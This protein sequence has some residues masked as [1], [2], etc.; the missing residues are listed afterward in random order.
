M[1]ARRSLAS[2][3][4]FDVGARGAA[5]VFTV[6]AFFLFPASA[7]AQCGAKRSTCSSC[8]DGVHARAPARSAW[9]VDHAFAD[10]CTACHAGDGDAPEA[11]A[12]HAAMQAPLA[13]GGAPCR[14]CHADATAR[15]ERYASAIGSTPPTGGAGGAPPTT[16]TTTTTT[17]SSAVRSSLRPQDAFGIGLVAA[18]GA[19]VVAWLAR[20]DT[21][22]STAIAKLRS[23]SWSPYLGGVVLGIV[24]TISLAV[25]GHRL[26]GAG[27]YQHLSGYL[28]RPLSPSSIYWRHIVP[29]GLTWDVQIAIGALAGALVSSRLARTFRVR[30]MPDAGW[31]EAFG[32]RVAVRWAIAFFGS[33]LTEIGAGIAGGCTASLA[34]SGG[35]VL[36]PAAF[37]FM[38][39]MFAGG[40]PALAIATYVGRLLSVR[41]RR[42]P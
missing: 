30:T 1:R 41:R 21:R 26:S 31:R 29:T 9:H 2:R 40:I 10:V 16:T 39:G 20:R 32:D 36:A 24:V 28:G 15:A 37:V 6:A 11:T 8:H 12:A 14:T 33:M 25:F 22:V 18:L 13:N 42:S 23:S 17:P 34:V 3:P 38:A 19:A 4:R 7:E 5:A 35:A 27:A